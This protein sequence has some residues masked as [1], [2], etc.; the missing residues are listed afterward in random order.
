MPCLLR[1]SGK[2]NETSGCN[3][4]CEQSPNAHEG[5]MMLLSMIKI[6]MRKRKDA[7][8]EERTLF[9]SD[10]FYVMMPAI[11]GRALSYDVLPDE[12]R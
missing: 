10:L 8:R 12:E 5:V 2:K 3:D 4:V 11:Q 9:C 7:P 1:Q 6:K